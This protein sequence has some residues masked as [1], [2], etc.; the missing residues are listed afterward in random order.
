MISK[1]KNDSYIRF[2]DL[3]PLVY[4]SQDQIEKF[5]PLKIKNSLIIETK[6]SD[7]KAYDIAI[8]LTRK[9][10]ASPPSYLTSPMIREMVCI[11]L[12]EQGLEKERLL[13]TRIGFPFADIDK[14]MNSNLKEPEKNEKIFTH[15]KKEHAAV[16]DLIKKQDTKE[17]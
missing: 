13:Y 11:I 15:I 17:S 2:E 4:T 12:I 1:N 3:L 16:R 14:I 7:R 6:M 9:L 8:L 5:N 10:V